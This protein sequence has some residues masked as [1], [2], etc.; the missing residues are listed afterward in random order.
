VGQKVD[1]LYWDLGA[2]LAPLAG[3]IGKAQGMLRGLSKAVMTPIGLF[4]TLG[5]VA[6][7]AGVKAT[8]M[9]ADFDKALREVSTLLPTTVDQM[10]ELRNGI[11][12]LSTKVPEPPVQLTKG[13]YQVIS[14]GI[15]DTTDAMVVLAASAKAATAGMSDTFTAVD[16]ITT[17][18]N[19]YQ[20]NAAHATRV[21][22]V[23]FA[24]IA[25]G[26]INFTQLAA[27]IG[28]VATTA[29]LA[30]VSI[31]EIGA[32]LATMTKFGINAA[33]AGTSLN[34]FMLSLINGTPEAIAMAK[35]LGIEFD[36]TALKTQGL[37]GMMNEMA[38]ATGGNIDKLAALSPE[39]RALKATLILAAEGNA[40]F[41]RVLG[42]TNGSMGAAERAF[43]KM[44][45]ALSEQ[46][47]LLKNKVNVFWY[48]LGEIGLPAASAA[49]KFFNTLLSDTNKLWGEFY[50]GLS[51]EALAAMTEEQLEIAKAGADRLMNEMKKRRDALAAAPE[52]GMSAAEWV[53]G[54]EDVNRQIQ[55][56]EV[57]IT[58]LQGALQRFTPIVDLEAAATLAAAKATA[59]LEA[60]LKRL[61]EQLYKISEV[62]LASDLDVWKQKF[63]FL[64]AAIDDT[65]TE[66]DRL[67]ITQR[68]IEQVNERVEKL[69]LAWERMPNTIENSVVMVTAIRRALTEAGRTWDDINPSVKEFIDQLTAFR[70]GPAV[71][72]SKKLDDMAG[73]AVS[74]AR[75]LTDAARAFG[76]LGDS[77]VANLSA[78]VNVMQHLNEIAG[79]TAE[80]I[81][82][83]SMLS[84]LGKVS[85]VVGIVAGL[86]SVA[87]GLFGGGPSEEEILRIEALKQNT[88]RL[89]ELTTRI[90]QLRGLLSG[91]EGSLIDAAKAAAAEAMR[92]DPFTNVP[93]WDRVTAVLKSF[94][95]TLKD[96]TDLAE[97]M[98]YKLD[99]TTMSWQAF[100]DGLNLLLS[101]QLFETFAGQISMI[102]RELDMF[103][104]T[105]PI[106]KLEMF[107]EAL[108][109]YSKLSV[110][111]KAKVAGFD[112]STKEGRAAMD[113]WIRDTWTDIKSGKF[114]LA[115][116][117]NMSLTE[118]LDFLSSFETWLDDFD[119]TV[120][121][122][123]ETKAFQVSRSITEVTG[124]RIAGI[125][126]TVSYWS[127]R[128]A[129]A[130]E[131]LAMSLG[132]PSIAP[133]SAAEMSAFMR[134]GVSAPALAS[135]G[136][137]PVTVSVSVG[138]I[139]VNGSVDPNATAQAVS[140]SFVDKV[141]RAL[142]ERLREVRRARG[143]A[144]PDGLRS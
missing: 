6:A 79:K 108:L 2:N 134:S 110:E 8:R 14:A 103:D 36:I 97:E 53:K 43:K 67:L 34:R 127:E 81:S 112:L 40:E 139:V 74:L 58:Q 125:L 141:D 39:I 41:N 98:G 60:A 104:V 46:W 90:G 37:G 54:R 122:A 33:E 3:G 84:G 130:V 82:M 132:V 25:E 96:L 91:T 71:D 88:L 115:S 121:D 123:G 1:E 66:A 109:K 61:G 137:G 28:D 117:G 35:E 52:E 72:V 64:R 78:V 32:A 63:E 16:A 75:T 120:E 19:A 92:V 49:L 18:L 50:G 133:P 15:T 20:L 26:K 13:L 143:L 129:T 101:S 77:G 87:K 17:V 76:V 29:A 86:A 80:G 142:G 4:G 131:R 94:G 45:G 11:V 126:T 59:A 99:L 111:E 102:Q 10:G 27:T 113:K 9:A 70:L 62:T 55:L 124:N 23:F 31:E 100:L 128:T 48:Q 69:A 106:K 68:S 24:T 105:D 144:M 42:V 136:G 85:A 56:Q 57:R 44:E 89:E 138:D 140:V 65:V 107:R 47:Q 22:D 135:A 30:G 118:F 93:M 114:E 38:K 21:S 119:K 7:L 12:E 73:D 5:A 51:T 83:W 116:L 95:Y